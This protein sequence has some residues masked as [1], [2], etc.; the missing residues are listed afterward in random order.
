MRD[1]GKVKF[2]FKEG[3]RYLEK[4]NKV[5]FG[6]GFSKRVNETVDSEKKTRTFQRIH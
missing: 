6:K 3:S 5:V 2:V 1:R 4:A